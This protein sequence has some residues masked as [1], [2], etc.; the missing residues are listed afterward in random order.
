M[1]LSVSLTSLENLLLLQ[2]ELRSLRSRDRGRRIPP[3]PSRCVAKWAQVGSGSL[4]FLTFFALGRVLGAALDFPLSQRV[5][6]LASMMQRMG[7]CMCP[8]VVRSRETASHV[9]AH[10][11]AQHS[12]TQHGAT[13]RKT[14]QRST[15]H[16]LAQNST[17]R[18]SAAQNRTA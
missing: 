4:I 7:F 18:Y 10:S 16:R 9:T 8:C 17:A 2:S 6:L 12:I 3:R 15:A 11:T 1:S 5:E 14:A 13:Q